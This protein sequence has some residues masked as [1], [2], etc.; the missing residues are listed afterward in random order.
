MGTAAAQT[1]KQTARA[2]HGFSAFDR[3]QVIAQQLLRNTPD[4]AHIGEEA[5]G[6]HLSP[7][8]QHRQVCALGFVRVREQLD[9]VCACVHAREEQA[10]VRE[11]PEH[12]TQ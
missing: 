4:Q 12:R 3:K 5:N 1:N 11:Q 6:R 10:R 2:Y 7:A 8:F 9:I